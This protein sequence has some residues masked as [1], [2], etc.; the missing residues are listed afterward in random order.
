M[1]EDCSLFHSFQICSSFIRTRI[2]NHHPVRLFNFHILVFD[3]YYD[4]GFQ[5]FFFY[6]IA[7]LKSHNEGKNSQ[8]SV[9]S[10]S[11]VTRREHST[12]NSIQTV[13]KKFEGT[14]E[15]TTKEIILTRSFKSDAR[16]K[17]S[18]VVMQEKLI[19]SS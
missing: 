19:L 16:R 3:L 5:I 2:Y 6:L 4:S 15:L 13:Q 9:S 8:F 10:Y 11:N 17:C 14:I 18:P 7:Q 1:C 12:V